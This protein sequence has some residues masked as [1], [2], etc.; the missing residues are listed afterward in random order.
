MYIT[1]ELH[2]GKAENGNIANP[3]SY[4]EHDH[5]FNEASSKERRFFTGSQNANKL[6]RPVWST[7][8]E[9]PPDSY[10]D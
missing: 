10:R 8:L 2:P 9:N 7:A 6:L 3:N 1:A 4:R 5:F